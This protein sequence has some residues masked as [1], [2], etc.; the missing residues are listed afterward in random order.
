MPEEM[1]DREHAVKRFPWMMFGLTV[2]AVL[3]GPL[4]SLPRDLEVVE[5]HSGV[6]AVY[7][8]ARKRGFAAEGFDKARVHGV[9]DDPNSSR[10]EDILLETGFR[11]ALNLV[12]RLKTGALLW[13]SPV[14][15]TF[16]A[17]CHTPCF[18]KEENGYAGDTT[19]EA[20]QRGNAMAQA[21]VFLLTLAWARGVHIVLENKPRMMKYL[22]ASG[23]MLFEPHSVQCARCAF[24]DAPDGQRWLKKYS[25]WSSEGWLRQ[26]S[27]PCACTK[28]ALHARL[29]RTEVINGKK[30]Y[31]TVDR[32]ALQQ[33]AA[34]PLRMG[35][36]VVDAWSGAREPIVQS[37]LPSPL[38]ALHG[39]EDMVDEHGQQLSDEDCIRSEADSE[40]LLMSPRGMGSLLSSPLGTGHGAKDMVEEH[41]QQLSDED[42]ILSSEADSESLL[43]S[44]RGM[45][46][47]P[48][49]A[50]D[51]VHVAKHAAEG[52]GQQLSEEDCILG[53]AESDELGSAGADDAL[54]KLE[55]ESEA[56]SDDVLNDG[57]GSVDEP[58]L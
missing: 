25:L 15:S 3:S 27:C 57:P 41:G 11:N 53:G 24:S 23:A 13:L 1:R 20:V 22:V 7:R 17:L 19:R 18:R 58:L 6:G 4:A 32:K 16:S 52:H 42:C 33:A 43:M 39:A 47:P 55:D 31:N 38:D 8:A 14:C 51:A 26:L 28:P 36:A 2:A 10:S 21:A 37:P 9:T 12:L 5:L 35:E 40:S 56:V 50:R 54:M 44:P 34:Y 49:S 45:G 30:A 48:A 46:S 29:V